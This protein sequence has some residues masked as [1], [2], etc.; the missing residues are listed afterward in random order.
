[1]GKMKGNPAL[2]E[3]GDKGMPSTG[4]ITSTTFQSGLIERKIDSAKL[5]ELKSNEDFNQ[6]QN[7]EA[8]LKQITFNTTIHLPK[9]AKNAS[10]S[11]LTL[12]DD[13][14]TVRIKYTLLDMM[15]TPK[16]LEFKIEY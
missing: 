14:K 8:M 7:A 2:A 9:V 13:K 6:M 3:M 5:N 15:K 12:S 16:A 10:G 11:N 1:M 4:E